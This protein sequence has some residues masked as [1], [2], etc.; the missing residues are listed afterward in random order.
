MTRSSAVPHSPP[1]VNLVPLDDAAFARFRAVAI[2]DYAEECVRAERWA[3]AEE[4][5]QQE[6]Y[7]SVALHVFGFN[8]PA[9]GL[10]RSRDYA[11]SDM[12][13]EKNLT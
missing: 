3:A 10:Y 8:E 13:M 7:R 12:V 2:A 9:I 1:G 5:I 4:A 6:G 11:I